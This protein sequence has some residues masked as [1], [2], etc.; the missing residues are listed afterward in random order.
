MSSILREDQYFDN[1]A[2]FCV[3][4]NEDS[5][6][7]IEQLFLDHRISYFVKEEPK[8]W[9]RRLLSLR[10]YPDAYVIRINSRDIARAAQL[11]EGIED[12]E[13]TGRIPQEDWSPKEKLRRLREAEERARQQAEEE[14]LLRQAQE[15]EELAET[16]H[17]GEPQAETD[18]AEEIPVEAAYPDG[19]GTA[20]YAKQ[21]D[22]GQDGEED[23]YE[24]L[25]VGDL[26]HSDKE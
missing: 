25:T 10:R 26:I 4:W 24:G 17:S 2:D 18:P 22:P 1:E 21:E 6:A 23:P 14:E 5:K 19:T 16:E 7:E 8:P 15:E 11:V 12:V 13:I 20:H 9:Y 3:V